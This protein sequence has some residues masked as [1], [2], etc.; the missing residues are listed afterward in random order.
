MTHPDPTSGTNAPPHPVRPGLLPGIALFLFLALLVFLTI[1]RLNPPDAV[2]PEAPPG[3]FSSGR[4]LNYLQS[5]SKNPHPVGSFEHQQ[6]R[7]YILAELSALGLNSEL[8]KT[9]TTPQHLPNNSLRAG[10]VEN[11]VARLKGNSTGGSA[12]ALMLVGHYDSRPIAFGASDDGAAVAAMLETLRALRAGPTLGNDIIFLFTDAEET[13]LHGARAFMDEHPWAKDVGLVLNFEARGTSGPVVMFETSQGNTWLIDALAKA[14]HPVATSLM[15]DVYRLLPNDTDL[16]V[17]KSS[18]LAGMN[19]AYLADSTHY[20][21]RLDNL[22]NLDERSLQH[23]GSYALSLATYFGNSNLNTQPRSNAIYFDLLG[24]KLI[25]YPAAL[26][27]PLTLLVFLAFVVVL[28][29]GLRSGQVTLAKT[30]LSFLAFVLTM[31]VAAG[32]VLL[33]W[34]L[35]RSL[36]SG[37][38]AMAPFDVYHSGFYFLSFSALT[39]AIVSALCV[40]GRKRLG[41]QNLVFGA[42]F[43]ELLL[44]LVSSLYLPGGTYLLIWPMLA[45]LIALGFLIMKKD[46]EGSSTIGATVLA[47]GAAP[48]ILLLVPII[49]LLFITLTVNLAGVVTLLIVL[50]LGLLI[51]QL[52]Y[53]TSHLRWLLPG[54]MFAA[55]LLCIALG[56]AYSGFDKAHPR[57]DNLFYGLNADKHEAVWASGDRAPDEWTAQFI[58]RTPQAGPLEEFFPGTPRNYLKAPAPVAILQ[59]PD[60]KVINDSMQGDVRMLRLRLTSP[61]QAP[62]ISIY[63][64]PGAE[65]RKVAING[66]LETVKQPVNAKI[67][68]VM[69]Y[70]ALPAEGIELTLE[71][72]P[73]QPLKL[74]V[75]DQSYGLPPLPDITSKTRPENVMPSSSISSDATFVRRSFSF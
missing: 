39:A 22:S 1:H 16:T 38:Q 64:E 48:A 17:F 62:L 32:G 9:T 58:S 28:L 5:I 40:L 49:Y 29:L 7:D 60:L 75:V 2:S 31:I 72:N 66:K 10:S 18:G 43:C 21:T 50:F 54:V 4:A 41:T 26:V 51:P 47:L 33:V 36:R 37:Y 11:V 34:L 15:Y 25:R 68:W 65:I 23:Q 56:L 44:L 46:Q 74:V 69:R 57:P 24:A 70:S 3:E 53:L 35:I 59:A 73:S 8:Q 30:V 52:N 14:P 13:G 19:F 20:H 42:L 55:S 45:S 63:A 61:R 67:P 27:W 6:V 12:R 71:T